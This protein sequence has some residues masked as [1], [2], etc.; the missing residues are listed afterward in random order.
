MHGVGV[1][2]RVGVLVGGDGL[3]A[4]GVRVGVEVTGEGFVGVGVFVVGTLVPVGGTAVAVSGGFGV[5]VGV[6]VGV[7]VC[8]GVGEGV[9]VAGNG[10]SG[11]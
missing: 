10:P 11:G 3:V 8:K 9:D 6:R 4:V 2:V 7:A 1:M 5:R